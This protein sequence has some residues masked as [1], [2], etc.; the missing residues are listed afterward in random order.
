M[1]F[2]EFGIGNTW[3]VRTETEL[4]DGTEYEQKGIVGPLKFHSLYIR[5]WIDKTVFIFDSKECFKRMKKKRSEFKLIIGMTS[6]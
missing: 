5:I 1:K 3:L 4:E 6:R 2:I